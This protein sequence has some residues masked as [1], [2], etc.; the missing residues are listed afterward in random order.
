MSAY[1]RRQRLAE[2]I[3]AQRARRARIRQEAHAW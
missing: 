2:A 3:A 1:V